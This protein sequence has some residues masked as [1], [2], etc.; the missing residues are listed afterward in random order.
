MYQ[1]L[2]HIPIKVTW[3]PQGVPFSLFVLLVGLGLAGALWLL[4]SHADRL[5]AAPETF[6]NMA[7]GVAV[8][9]ALVAGLITWFGDELPDGVPIY[10]F[11]MMLFLAFLA[12]TWLGGRRGER[13]GISK[14]TIQDLAIWVF[15][16]GLLGARIA[17]LLNEG[18]VPRDRATLWEFLKRLPRIWDGGIILYGSVLGALASYALGY[19][20]VFRKRRVQ[21]LRLLDVVAPCV[22]L[23]LC[24]GRIGCFL[25]GCCFGQVACASCALV[26]PA[27]SF[28]MSAPP[29]EVL[30][31]QGYQTPAGFT[32]R[33]R[34][35]AVLV[36]EVDAR[37]QAHDKGLRPGA[38]ILAVNGWKITP[39]PFDEIDGQ[40]LRS[41]QFN[42]AEGNK[43]EITGLPALSRVLR[44]ENWPRGESRV[45]LSFRARPGAE[46]TTIDLYPRT[47]GLYPTQIYEVI[48][49]GLLLLVLLAYE[50]FRRHPGQV[51]AVLLIG[52]GLHRY[53][54]EILRDDPRPVGFERFGSVACVL[55]GVA[56][57]AYL[58]W[59]LPAQPAA[60]PGTAALPAPAGSAGIVQ[61]PAEAVKPGP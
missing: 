25:N 55:V 53:L 54:N 38:E 56:L 9:A 28:P 48:S 59:F 44:L 18:F 40:K 51:A 43:H 23:G 3:L 4:A 52:Y 22:A 57:W 35:G 34:P 26:G 32:V 20:L 16:G 49:M 27:A 45:T 29:R 36:A 21:T 24:L 39:A 19:F 47:L 41:L 17:F 2:F 5:R 15:V 6:R 30:V 14:E 33:S 11:G 13:E 60:P 42:D 37:S 10:G 1:V 7:V 31:E 8:L 61:A 12:C 50:S 58:Q 46:P